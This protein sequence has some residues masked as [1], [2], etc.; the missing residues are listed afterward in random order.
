MSTVT[1]FNR[2]TLKEVRAKMSEALELAGEELGIRFDIGNIRF[3]EAT[4]N[5][6]VDAF[7]E[8]A[9]AALKTTDKL[10][11]DSHCGR[12]GLKPSDHGVLFTSKRTG[13]RFKLKSI[14]TKNRKYPIVAEKIG[15]GGRPSGKTFK[16]V[17]SEVKE[18]LAAER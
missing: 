15:F 18:S 7:I 4:C 16:F 17:A 6:K 1:R 3:S 5:I 8:D 14:K 9:A 2:H 11:W 10:I 12:Y 13:E